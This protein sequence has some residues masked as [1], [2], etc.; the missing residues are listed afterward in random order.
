MLTVVAIGM[1][2]VMVILIAAVISLV[3]PTGV[4]IPIR[5]L[6]AVFAVALLRMAIAITE[7]RMVFRMVVAI[8]GAIGVAQPRRKQ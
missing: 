2:V 3:I 8:L 5:M 4:S 7:V 1:M 6:L